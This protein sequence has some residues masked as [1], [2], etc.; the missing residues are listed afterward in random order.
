MD[1]A[2]SPLQRHS[3]ENDL[4]LCTRE[5]HR[6]R[7][8]IGR[9]GTHTQPDIWILETVVN[10][11]FVRRINDALITDVSGSSKRGP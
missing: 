1:I 11:F 2:F 9:I 10:C 3:S 7:T 4:R 8:R 5:L 6:E